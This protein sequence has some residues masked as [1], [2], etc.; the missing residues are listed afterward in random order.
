MKGWGL[1]QFSQSDGVSVFYL[2]LTLSLSSFPS[3]SVWISP[4]ADY[5]PSRSVVEGETYVPPSSL[6]L[7]FVSSRV[8]FP[9]ITTRVRCFFFPLRRCATTHALPHW[10]CLRYV[11]CVS[12]LSPSVSFSPSIPLHL[13][14][15]LRLATGGSEADVWS[16]EKGQV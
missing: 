15:S 4:A 14:L 16:T 12:A 10:C 8:F 6:A 13:S 3:S 7:R 5:P 1:V 2:S 9:A 11:L